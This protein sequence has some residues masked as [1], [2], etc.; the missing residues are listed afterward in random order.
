MRAVPPLF[1]FYSQ[2][3]SFTNISGQVIP[4]PL[5]LVFDGLPRVDNF[6]CKNGCGVYLLTPTLTYCKSIGG[7]TIVQISAG[8]LAPG[9][10]IVEQ[11]LF[12]PG[13]YY[14]PDLSYT[15]VVVSGNPSK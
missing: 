7:S 13:P 12:L 3:I 15:P 4:G 9:Q 1:N 10:S 6:H 5:N 11:F 14:D 2:S 8:P